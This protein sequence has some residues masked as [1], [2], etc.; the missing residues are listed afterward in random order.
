MCSLIGADLLI[1]LSDID[2]LYTDDPNT[3]PDAKFISIAE[4]IDDNLMMMGKKSTTSDVGTGGMA[5]KLIAAKIATWSGADMVI[6]NSDH[7]SVIEEILNAEEKGTVFPAHK[8][9]DFDVVKFIS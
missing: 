2:G 8:K 5:T 6:A 9:E 1:L 3:N 7:V 4:N